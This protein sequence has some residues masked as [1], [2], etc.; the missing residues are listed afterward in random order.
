MDF[1]KRLLHHARNKWYQS[2]PGSSWDC[3]LIPRAFV[4]IWGRSCVDLRAT[5]ELFVGSCVDLKTAFA[6]LKESD[7]VEYIILETLLVFHFEVKT[8]S[9]SC[10]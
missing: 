1:S 4:S 10:F 2:I 9:L 5:L 3:V 6:L 8:L 7:S